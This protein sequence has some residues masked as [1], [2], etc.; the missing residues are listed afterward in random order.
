M[1][2]KRKR[3]QSSM[4]TEGATLVSSSTQPKMA[5]IIPYPQQKEKEISYLNKPHILF[6]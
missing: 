2:K 6:K 1:E 3:I 5:K 4:A